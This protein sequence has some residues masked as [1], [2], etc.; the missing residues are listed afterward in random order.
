M[1]RGG[2]GGGVR[3]FWGEVG[4]VIEGWGEFFFVGVRVLVGG[5]N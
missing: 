4:V 3:D 2:D 1:V 5:E